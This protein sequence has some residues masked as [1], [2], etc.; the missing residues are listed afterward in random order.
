MNHFAK[1]AAQLESRDLDGMLLTHEAN[2]FYAS[3][4]HSA[5]TDGMALVTREKFY[6][7][8]D[9]RYTEADPAACAGC[10]G[11]GGRPRPGLFRPADG[12]RPAPQHP[13]P[14]V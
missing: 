12:G 11:P 10:G 2:R 7:F 3:G 6:Y 14:G 13:A 1:I 4:F 9:S 5:G 8:T